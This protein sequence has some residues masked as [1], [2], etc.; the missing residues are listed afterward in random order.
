MKRPT[1][2]YR[3][4]FWEDKDVTALKQMRDKY[5]FSQQWKE[6]SQIE[7]MSDLETTHYNDE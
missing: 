4:F 1:D 2:S 6:R 7:W 3:K 5:S